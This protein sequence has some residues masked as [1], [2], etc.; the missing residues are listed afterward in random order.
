[1]EPEDSA[2]ARSQLVN[3]LLHHQKSKPLLK[4]KVFSV[5]SVLRLYIARAIK[6][7]MSVP[8]IETGSNTSTTALKS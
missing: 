6:E 4:N 2:A 1:M 5:H 3:M 7:S 8:C